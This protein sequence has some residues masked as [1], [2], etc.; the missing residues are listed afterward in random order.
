M[1]NFKDLFLLNPDIHFLNFGSFGACPAP[2]FENYQ[3]WQRQ[4]EWE[5]VQMIA[6]DGVG[7]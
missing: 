7:F 4:L 2:I 5:P 3:Y 6:F 1:P